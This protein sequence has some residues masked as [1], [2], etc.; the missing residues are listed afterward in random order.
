M[1]YRDPG[2]SAGYIPLCQNPKNTA[3]LYALGFFIVICVLERTLVYPNGQRLK[4]M[5]IYLHVKYK[6]L[7]VGTSYVSKNINILPRIGSK[8]ARAFGIHCD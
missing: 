7:R 6:F 3:T 8:E 4:H 2:I 1:C 5:S